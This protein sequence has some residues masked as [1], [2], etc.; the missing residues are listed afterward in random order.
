MSIDRMIEELTQYYEAAGFVDYFEH[1][2]KGK[3]DDE[4]RA[5]F[6]A[7]RKANIGGDEPDGHPEE[8]PPRR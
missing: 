8:I 4:I 6:E 1:Q 7:Y 5:M 3:G 2:L